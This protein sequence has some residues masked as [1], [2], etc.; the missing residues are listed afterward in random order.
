MAGFVAEDN[1]Q[2]CQVP[3][4]WQEWAAAGLVLLNKDAG[5]WLLTNVGA[6][7]IADMLNE[8]RGTEP[9]ALNRLK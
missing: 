2:K 8:L 4:L 7:F 5:G 6:W 1:S 9:R 3:S